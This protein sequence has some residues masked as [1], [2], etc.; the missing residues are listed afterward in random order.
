MN[1]R[2]IV[3]AREVLRSEDK[4]GFGC[5]PKNKFVRDITDEKHIVYELRCGNPLGD[6]SI[7]FE[8]NDSDDEE[9][10]LG[11]IPQNQNHI[12]SFDSK[13]ES[14]IIS[15]SDGHQT[16]DENQ[17]EEEDEFDVKPDL[18]SLLRQQREYIQQAALQ[19]EIKQEIDWNAHQYNKELNGLN[20]VQ[21]HVVDCV[22]IL[23][24]SDDEVIYEPENKRKKP[25]SEWSDSMMAAPKPLFPKKPQPQSVQPEYHP[26]PKHEMSEAILKEKVKNVRESRGQQLSDDL[27]KPNELLLNDLSNRPST[28]TNYTVPNGYRSH[29]K[30]LNF[31]DKLLQHEQMN[32]FISDITRWDVKRITAREFQHT[33][34]FHLPHLMNIELSFGDNLE[35]YKRKMK[36]FTE[37]ELYS[38]IV[39][40]FNR[41]SR[42]HQIFTQLLPG[43]KEEIRGKEKRFVFK[44]KGEAFEL[45]KQVLIQKI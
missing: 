13:A 22:E 45:N 20:N 5:S 19:R 40:E 23:D 24:D 11:Q 32:A 33:L 15:G 21:P 29:S 28:S 36:S 10:D 26:P 43:Y 35:L 2:K 37:L 38:N 31:F 25:D 41:K 34:E 4:I 6:G 39:D 17:E 8:I 30:R 7:P 42:T 3:N 9:D 18:A 1:N 12:I 44:C 27:F 16:D 14:A